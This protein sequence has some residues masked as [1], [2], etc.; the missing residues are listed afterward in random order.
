MVRI[1]YK[2]PEPGHSTY[3]NTR[4]LVPKVRKNGPAW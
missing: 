1:I 4:F 3:S 2:L